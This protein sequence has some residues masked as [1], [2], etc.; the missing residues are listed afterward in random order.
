M[1]DKVIIKII[2]LILI[3]L[4]I[5]TGGLMLYSLMLFKNL[6]KVYIIIGVAIIIYI[7]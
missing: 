2:E 6:E 5:L 3:V 7:L 4:L 1:K